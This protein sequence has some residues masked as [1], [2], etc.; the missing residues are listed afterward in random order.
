MASAAPKNIKSMWVSWVFRKK[1]ESQFYI[2]S[3]FSLYCCIGGIVFY[4]HTSTLSC[5]RLYS[6]IVATMTNNDI[7]AIILNVNVLTENINRNI[8]AS[9]ANFYI[10]TEV[11]YFYVGTLSA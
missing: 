6:D 9:I 1:N 8:W 7:A 2:F 3:Y 5:I 11:T 10:F 4:C